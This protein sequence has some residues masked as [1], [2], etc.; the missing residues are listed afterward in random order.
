MDGWIMNLGIASKMIE[1]DWS[2]FH[3]KG[4]VCVE[5]RRYLHHDVSFAAISAQ[6][7]SML[8]GLFHLTVAGLSLCF[9]S[10]LYCRSYFGIVYETT[11]NVSLFS[12]E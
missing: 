9:K 7:D 2:S 8:A 3:W 10:G 4:Y 11:L 5:E 1:K 6:Q 12:S